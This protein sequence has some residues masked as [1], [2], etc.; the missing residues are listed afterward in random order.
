ML[1]MK[2]NKQD[3]ITLN[4]NNMDH[5]LDRKALPDTHSFS[6]WLCVV[7]YLLLMSDFQKN[8]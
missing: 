5:S 8:L 1:S 7:L 2:V 4:V 6:H 3:F